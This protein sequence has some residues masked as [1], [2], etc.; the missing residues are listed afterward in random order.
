M[1]GEEAW[2]DEDD[3]A[4][5]TAGSNHLGSGPREGIDVRPERRSGLPWWPA[6][7]LRF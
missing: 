5:L 7:R 1:V 2:E 4:E 6:V 3:A